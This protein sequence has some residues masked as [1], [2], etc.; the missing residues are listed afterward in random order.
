MNDYLLEFRDVSF[1]YDE[2]EKESRLILK[3]INL[4]VSRGEFIAV[5]GRNGSGKSTLAKLANAVFLPTEGSLF[6]DGTDT[7]N[8]DNEF[9]IRKKI[10]VVLQNPDNQIVASIVEEDVAF[11][12][13]NLGIEPTEI[14]RRVDEALKTVGMYDY[15]LHEPHK[16]SGGQKQ[17]V[18]IAGIIA[19]M[20]D[21]II[22]DE[23]TAMLDPKGRREVMTAI[24]KLNSE[25]GMTVIFI[26]HLMNEAAEADRIVILDKGSI[27]ADGSPYEV[28]S[29][30]KLLYDCGLGLPDAAAIA[31]QLRKKGV[32]LPGDIFTE[33]Q[34]IQQY[35]SYVTGS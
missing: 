21:C 13:E 10:G 33:K 34:L 12:P 3:N 1:T 20:P 15:R 7:K 32:A 4:K 9:E 18:A 14:R 2:D 8:T 31:E 24:K 23:S 30:K 5:L 25:F 29:D 16:L 6:V 17:R 19:M 11:G 22:L 27:A 28:F 35:F 26:T